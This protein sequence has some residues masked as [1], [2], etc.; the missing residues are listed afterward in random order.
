MK[1][2]K[3]PLFII[4]DCWLYNLQNKTIYKY[5]T[6]YNF[7]FK[8]IAGCTIRNVKIQNFLKYIA[9]C[10]IHN[11]KIQNFLKYIAGCTTRNMFQNF[12]IIGC[13]QRIF[14]SFYYV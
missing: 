13:K 7:F 2:L 11:V 5:I 8:Y 12:H 3:C 6:G 4:A 10:T 1:R 9:G 14:W